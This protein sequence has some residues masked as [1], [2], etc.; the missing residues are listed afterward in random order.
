MVNQIFSDS[1]INIQHHSLH[2]I[3][4]FPFAWI[5][6]L[7]R[8]HHNGITFACLFGNEKS[9]PIYLTEFNFEDVLASFQS[10]FRQKI[11]YKCK[12]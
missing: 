9:E 3:H 12:F 6:I 4:Y 1:K 7:H 2:F 5:S 10:I 8:R 11:V